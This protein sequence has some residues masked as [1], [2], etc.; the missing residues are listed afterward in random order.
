MGPS[1]ASGVQ[2]SLITASALGTLRQ[3]P[4]VPQ[5]EVLLSPR[6][7][8]QHVCD[9]AQTARVGTCRV[10]WLIHSRKRRFR[11]P[12]PKH[13]AGHD[14]RHD[15]LLNAPYPSLSFPLPC[16]SVGSG[17]TMDWRAGRISWLCSRVQTPWSVQS[18]GAISW[19]QGVCSTSFLL[20]VRLQTGRVRVDKRA[21]F[22]VLV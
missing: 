2:R 14:V 9:Y 1:P 20:I 10:W 7:V 15:G 5:S 16:C 19:E 6:Y 4:A 22:T 12:L 18:A 11:A 13:S 3:Q 17:V 8:Q 21:V